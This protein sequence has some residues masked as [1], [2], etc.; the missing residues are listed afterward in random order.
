MATTVSQGFETLPD[1]GFVAGRGSAIQE[2]NATVEELARTDIPVLFHGESGSGKEVY[3]RLLHRLSANGERVLIKLGCTLVSADELVALA[4]RSDDSEA[5]LLDNVDEL[6]SEC[7]RVLLSV[8]QDYENTARRKT[9]RLIS[10]STKDLDR[11]ATAG[12]FRRELYYR[13]AAVNLRLPSL[14]ER[15]EDIPEFL[16]CFLE[17]C[18]AK[19]GRKAP[20]VGEEE[21]AILQSYDWPGNV[22][23]LE[24]LAKRIAALGTLGPT[25]AE[26][27]LSRTHAAE[28]LRPGRTSLKAVAREASRLAEREL[29]LKALE[30]THW[31]RKQAAKQL[32]ISYKALLYKIKQIEVPGQN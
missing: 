2:L 13:L 26:I 9:C 5:L 21:I 31:N 10:T 7:Q 12:R 23:E 32:Q 20:A 14:R 28:P 1:R 25:L 19:M 11:E 6:D 27:R 18:A 30:R 24:N 8:L 4:H 15:K 22:R 3:A 16:R 29:I 17:H